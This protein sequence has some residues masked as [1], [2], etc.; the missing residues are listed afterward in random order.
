MPKKAKYQREEILDKAYEMVRRHGEDFLSARSL[1]AELGTSTAPIFTA[2]SGI[3]EVMAGV[4]RKAEA[5]YR[6]YLDRGL[7]EPIPFKSAGLMYIKFAKD[8]P[9][10]FKLLFRN[11]KNEAPPTHYMPGENENEASVREALKSEHSI[12]DDKAMM[13]YNHLS[14]YAHGLASLY[15]DGICIFTDEDVSRMLSEMF[16]ALGATVGVKPKN[17]ESDGDKSEKNN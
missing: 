13:L 8:E 15:A 11:G 1:A 14:V 17:I 3:D 9:Q 16:T 2:F 5:Y 4:V 6:T 10:L 12:G 7:S